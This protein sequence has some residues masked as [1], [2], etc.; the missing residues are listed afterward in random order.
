MFV[1]V[2]G[3]RE[4][5]NIRA[6]EQTGVDWMGFICYEHSSRFV[7]ACPEYMPSHCRRVGVFVNA[8]ESYIYD[9]VKELHLHYVQLHGH[10]SPETCLRLQQA[11]L[12]VIKAFSICHAKEF[13]QTQVYTVSCDY[14]LFDTPCTTFG[15]SGTSFD[16]QILQA[17]NGQTPFLLS[18][19]ISPDSLGA[20]TKFSHPKWAGIDLNSRFETAPGIKD[21]ESLRTFINQFKNLPL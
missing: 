4:A 11:G 12:H 17:Y 19:G 1:K 2:C 14:F 9:K 5:E 8:T 18:G 7:D 10:E 15:G 16:W 3:M 6:V 21:A 20:L 13:Y